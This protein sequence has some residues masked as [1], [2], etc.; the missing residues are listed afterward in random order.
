MLV[1]CRST[2]HNHV[3]RVARSVLLLHQENYL[4]VAYNEYVLVTESQAGSSGTDVIKALQT[5][6]G[7][8]LLPIEGVITDPTQSVSTATTMVR[9]HPIR[10]FAPMARLHF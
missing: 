2:L 6:A 5:G 8:I 3:Y 9:P 1:R 7:D 10:L 4:S